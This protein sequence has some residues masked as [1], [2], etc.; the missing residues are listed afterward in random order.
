MWT[1]GGGKSRQ[2]PWGAKTSHFGFAS[3]VLGRWATDSMKR[4]QFFVIASSPAATVGANAGGGHLGVPAGRVLWCVCVGAC[5]Q[6]CKCVWCVYICVHKCVCRCVC[7]D[8]CAKV[9]V[10]VCVCMYR[11]VCMR[12][13]TC[14]PMCI[15]H[16]VSCSV[17]FSTLFPRDKVSHGTRS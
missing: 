2:S 12:I 9:C 4:L 3:S 5:V 11:C 1:P 14:I 8:V 7:T 15:E 13:Q 6:V 10:Q 16:C 17:T